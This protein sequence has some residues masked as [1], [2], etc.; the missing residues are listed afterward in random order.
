MHRKIDWAIRITLM[1]ASVI[2]IYLA[3]NREYSVYLYL[4]VLLCFNVIS[5]SVCAFF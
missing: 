4:V 5:A 3:F 1:I 2:A